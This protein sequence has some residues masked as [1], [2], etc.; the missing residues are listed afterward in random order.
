MTK[1]RNPDFNFSMLLILPRH[2]L[3]YCDE[4]GNENEIDNKASKGLPL[5]LYITL[6]WCRVVILLFVNAYDE[7]VWVPVHS[8]TMHFYISTLHY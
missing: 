7:R 2:F 8:F 5:V 3:I 6:H 1:S 4:Y